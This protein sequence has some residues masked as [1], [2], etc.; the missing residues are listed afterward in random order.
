[1]IKLTLQDDDT[2]LTFEV[3]QEDASFDN[4]L[5]GFLGCMFGVGYV[6]STE[7]RCF[8]E[9][10]EGMKPLYAKREIP[11]DLFNKDLKK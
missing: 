3:D 4:V 5:R 7:M 8:Q 10:I 2:K 1:M 11:E 9:Y 6:P